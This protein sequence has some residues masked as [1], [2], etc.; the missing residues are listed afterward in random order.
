M[1][2]FRRTQRSSH[3]TRCAHRRL[4]DRPSSDSDRAVPTSASDRAVPTSAQWS[5]V[6]AGA[7]RS[8]LYH[9]MPHA[10]RYHLLPTRGM[11]RMS[12]RQE[13]HRYPFAVGIPEQHCVGRRHTLV[14][15]HRRL[16]ALW[17]RNPEDT[18][19]WL[20]LIVHAHREHGQVAASLQKS[21]ILLDAQPRA[22][23]PGRAPRRRAQPALALPSRSPG[24]SGHA[25]RR[26]R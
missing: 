25:R 13:L 16:A 19:G 4:R 24:G 17:T 9:H 6:T 3:S 2:P 18:G 22:G 26:A 14:C 20:P 12:V 21:P 10:D 7:T 5:S 15:V 1:T 23:A 11:S 8:P